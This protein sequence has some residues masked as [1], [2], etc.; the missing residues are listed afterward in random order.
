MESFKK[1]LK[2]EASSTQEIKSIKA[3]VCCREHFA[4]TNVI[5][6]DVSTITSVR[7][8]LVA[9]K[10]AVTNTHRTQ[11]QRAHANVGSLITMLARRCAHAYIM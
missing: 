10:Q 2:T 9:M 11:T 7:G 4:K 8:R 6:H 1:Y 3:K 5:S